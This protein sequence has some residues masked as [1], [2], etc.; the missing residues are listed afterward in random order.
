MG[1]GY[2]R[3]VNVIHSFLGVLVLSALSCGA[4]NVKETRPIECSGSVEL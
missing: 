4:R 1:E 3:S 2:V